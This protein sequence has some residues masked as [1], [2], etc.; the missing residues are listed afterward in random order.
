MKLNNNPYNIKQYNLSPT[1]G[2]R[3]PPFIKYLTV[4]K[5]KES[6]DPG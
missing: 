6:K 1:A 5:L 3:V 2:E 4:A